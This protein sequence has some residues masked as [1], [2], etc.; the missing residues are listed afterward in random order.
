MKR[1]KR[2]NHTQT[3]ET[4]RL[5]EDG[6]LDK[7]KDKQKDKQTDKMTDNKTGTQTNI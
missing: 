5:T 7:K 1:N 6:L 4:N 2:Q 3:D